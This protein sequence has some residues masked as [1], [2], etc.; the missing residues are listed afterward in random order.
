MINGLLDTMQFLFRPIPA[1]QLG[2]TARGNRAVV[3]LRFVYDW[4]ERK[5]WGSAEWF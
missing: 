5:N 3:S 4:H 1:G 2:Q